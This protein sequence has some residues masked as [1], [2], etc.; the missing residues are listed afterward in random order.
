MK[1]NGGDGAS[2]KIATAVRT[3][4]GFAIVVILSP[5]A[6]FPT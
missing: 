1:S 4:L 6:R 3:A 2:S 5:K